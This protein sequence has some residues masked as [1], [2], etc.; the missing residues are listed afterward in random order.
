M[1]IAGRARSQRDRPDPV[2]VT[3]HGELNVSVSIVSP[4]RFPPS[5]THRGRRHWRVLPPDPSGT[6]LIPLIGGT[7]AVPPSSKRSTPFGA[8][9]DDDRETSISGDGLTDEALA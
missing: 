6:A 5:S 3:A 1:K 9:L 2:I 4:E 8:A 7:R